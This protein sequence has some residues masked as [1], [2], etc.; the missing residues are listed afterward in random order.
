MP[1]HLTHTRLRQR[2]DPNC[3]IQKCLAAPRKI[4]TGPIQFVSP[5]ARSLGRVWRNNRGPSPSDPIKLG[6]VFVLPIST[7]ALYQ[8]ATPTLPNNES[9][10]EM[11]TIPQMGDLG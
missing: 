6:Q 8:Y 5:D 10:M 1:V 2:A 9:T 4:F 7:T 11:D 3:C